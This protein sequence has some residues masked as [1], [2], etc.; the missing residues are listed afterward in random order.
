MEKDGWSSDVR[1]EEVLERAKEEMNI[2]RT[3][4]RRKVNWI[5]Y[6]L[7]RN[8]PLTQVIERKMAGRIQVTGKRGRRCKHLLDK[9]V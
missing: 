6:I 4:K 8:C 3:I 1:N 2:L 5:G 7:H 9:R